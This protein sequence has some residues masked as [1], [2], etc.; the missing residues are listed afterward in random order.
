VT[1]TPRVSICIP[2]YNHAKYINKTIMSVLEQDFQDLEIVVTDDCS[3]DGTVEELLTIADDRIRLFRHTH[4]MG[5]SVAANNNIENARGDFI[6]LLPSD[7]LFEPH[8]ISRQLAEFER[9]P[10]LGAVFSHMRFIDETG[11]PL[12]RE[13]AGLAYPADMDREAAL[14]HFFYD[15][16]CIAAPTAMIRRDV[17]AQVGSVD[18]RLLQTQDFEYW[19]RICL[20]FDIAVVEEPLV[21]YRIRAGQANMDA[22]T[23]AKCARI[24][25]EMPRVLE[26]FLDLTDRDLFLRVFPEARAHLDQGLGLRGA[27]AALALQAP[28]IWTRSFGIEALYRELGDPSTAAALDAAG[29]GF[30]YFF[31]LLAEVD[32]TR[33]IAAEEKNTE[34][35][36]YQQQLIEARDWWRKQAENWEAEYRRVI[37]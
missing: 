14:R 36:D 15:G 30:P 13:I 24:H 17:L 16:N 27:L 12:E 32:P 20:A 6:C 35:L 18:P 26:R 11:A 9:K 4:N 10:E 8:K 28:S 5:P 25:W 21:A 19:I 23:P 7:D 29:Y 2:A 1:Q 31:R 33:A 34:V 3:T 37:R 22:N